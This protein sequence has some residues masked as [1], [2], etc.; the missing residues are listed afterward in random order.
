MPSGCF[1]GW[2]G[3]WKERERIERDRHT[4]AAL[5]Y[6]QVEC[7]RASR[8]RAYHDVNPRRV[9]PSNALA[10]SANPIFYCLPVRY[11]NILVVF[12]CF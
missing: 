7:G 9:I 5:G 12:L 8:S 6:V 1:E 10:A 4:R 2:W 11:F 3:G